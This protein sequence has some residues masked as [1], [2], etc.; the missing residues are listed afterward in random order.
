MGDW[1]EE[2]VKEVKTETGGQEG[3]REKDGAGED[4]SREEGCR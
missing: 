1:T 4:K 3:R 2:E